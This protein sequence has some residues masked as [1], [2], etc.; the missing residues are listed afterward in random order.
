MNARV[1]KRQLVYTQVVQVH[2]WIHHA[3]LFCSPEH[4]ARMHAH[5]HS[6]MHANAHIENPERTYTPP[7]SCTHIHTDSFLLELRVR[8]VRQ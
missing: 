1:F 8:K 5:M 6:S 7:G 2:K 3:L 4:D